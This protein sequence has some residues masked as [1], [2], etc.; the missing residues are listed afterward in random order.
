MI[1]NSREISEYIDLNDKFLIVT[2]YNPD[3]DAIGS[4]LGLMSLLRDSGK[5]AD[6][7]MPHV[8]PDKYAKF[9]GGLVLT[10]NMPDLSAYSTIICVDFS[11]PERANL[12]QNVKI[13][14]LGKF[15]INIDHHPDNRLFGGL[16][17]VDPS[18]SA[19]AE[20]IYELAKFADFKFSPKAARFLLMGILADT[21]GFRFDNSSPRAL[22]TAAKLI[23]AGVDFGTLAKDLFFSK[24]LSVAK[25]E[26]EIIN[27][28]MKTAFDGRFAWAI[29]DEELFYKYGLRPEESEGLIDV[30]RC[31]E[32]TVAVAF[33][34]QNFDGFR[35]SLRSREKSFS[36]GKIARRIGGG[37]HE[38]A[39]GAF[40]KTNMADIAEKTL[41]DNIEKA[42]KEYDEKASF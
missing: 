15:L 9:A 4:S 1:D 14:S 40:I 28:R 30:I 12:P 23:D 20:V 38:L 34:Y 3:G 31:I 35:C 39:A 16:N 2:H 24:P 41:L 10:G 18:A 32:G 36:V 5:S 17:L 33:I 37:G 22:R 42:L 7:Y 11:S 21:G 13:D 27:N 6:F 26:A 25:L 29:L 8:V 19:A